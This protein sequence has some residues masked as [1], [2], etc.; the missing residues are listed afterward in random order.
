MENDFF[1]IYVTEGTSCEAH[2]LFGTQ[3]GDSVRPM[4]LVLTSL[5]EQSAMFSSFLSTT[6]YME[7]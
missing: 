4:G 7:L 6:W 1:S 5:I 2:G 3:G